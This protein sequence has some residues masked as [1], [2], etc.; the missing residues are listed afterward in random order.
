MIFL[1]NSLLSA[2][3][4]FGLSAQVFAQ[5][6]CKIDKIEGAT[7][8]F[9][10]S[11]LPT[12]TT[13]GAHFLVMRG[14][15]SLAEI[16][17]DRATGQ[18]RIVRLF[19][20]DAILPG[21]LVVVDDSTANAPVSP[22][23]PKASQEANSSTVSTPPTLPRLALKSLPADLTLDVA[24]DNYRR[25]FEARTQRHKFRQVLQQARMDNDENKILGMNQ[26]DA[27]MVA[28]SLS[29]GLGPS[30]FWGDPTFLLSS[31]YYAWMSNR[32]RN[33][34]FAGV[35]VQLEAEVTAWDP[36]LLESYGQYAAMVNGLTDT[37][38]YS[39]FVRN[40][41]AQ[42]G[43][44]NGKV[45][46]VKLKNIGQIKAQLSPFNWHAFMQGPNGTKVPA[47]RYDA[48]L[49]RQIDPGREVSGNVY[50]PN[51]PGDHLVLSLE[52]MY[53]DRH[54]MEFQSDF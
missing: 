15:K 10:K 47:S 38:K 19:A 16:E 42:R 28:E 39:E 9:D 50:F 8:F 34:L 18:G 44:A 1:R 21:D 4:G 3:V 2:V 7:V 25:L 41:Q 13:P 45:F 31:A 33:K 54:D 48:A 46:E 37:Q 27:Y 53:G 51:A 29:I 26:Q 22:T 52:D 12:T 24:E 30:G 40:L 49:D 5:S 11:S 32:D 14:T 23:V 43:V 35:E 20:P 6:T 36:A 17:V